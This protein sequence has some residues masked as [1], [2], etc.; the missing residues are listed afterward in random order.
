[1]RD[2]TCVAW[3]IWGNAC[4]PVWHAALQQRCIRRLIYM[5]QRMLPSL[6]ASFGIYEAT[7]VPVPRMRRSIY[8][9]QRMSPCPACCIAATLHARTLML[10]RS[11]DAKIWQALSRH[12]SNEELCIDDFL[13]C[14]PCKNVYRQL[15]SMAA[16]RKRL[17]T[18]F[19]HACYAFMLGLHTCHVRRAPRK[20]PRLLT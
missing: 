13:A 10:Q 4:C 3:Y 5:G 1:M 16:M 12:G 9:G 15:F 14:L 19:L 17:L 11:G 7:H 8:M 20:S 6:H 18:G 2:G